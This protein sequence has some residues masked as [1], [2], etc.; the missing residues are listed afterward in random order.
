MPSFCV[1]L[2]CEQKY[3]HTDDVSFHRFPKE[4]ELS[5][6]WKNFTGRCDDWHP[7]RWSAIC[8]RHFKDSDFRK[9]ATRKILK[10]NA[11]P[12]I[13]SCRNVGSN[14][15]ATN[16]NLSQSISKENVKVINDSETYENKIFGTDTKESK[17]ISFEHH[18]QSRDSNTVTTS[19]TENALNNVSEILS[20]PLEMPLCIESQNLEQ[21]NISQQDIANNDT[22]QYDINLSVNSSFLNF[23]ESSTAPCRLCGQE[24]HITNSFLNDFEI[25]GMIQKCMPTLNI[26]QDD[27]FSKEVCSNCLEQ[28]ENFNAF[29][30]QVILHQKNLMENVQAVKQLGKHSTVISS[31]KIKQEPVNN[32]KM[33]IKQEI[34][35][36]QISQHNEGTIDDRDNHLNSVQFNIQDQ[37]EPFPIEPEPKEQKFLRESS[38]LTTREIVKNCDIIEIIN[39]EDG[40]IDIPDDEIDDPQNGIE[41]INTNENHPKVIDNKEIRIKKKITEDVE[42]F[43]KENIVRPRVVQNVIGEHN[44]TRNCDVEFDLILKAN[45]YKQEEPEDQMNNNE[46]NTTNNNSCGE[47]HD[48]LTSNYVLH[49]IE[50]TNSPKKTIPKKEKFSEKSNPALKCIENKTSCDKKTNPMQIYI[51]IPKISPTNYN[52]ESLSTMREMENINIAPESTDCLNTP[53]NNL[54]ISNITKLKNSNKSNIVVINESILKPGDTQHFELYKCLE[55]SIQFFSVDNFKEHQKFHHSASSFNEIKTSEP[56]CTH[57]CVLCETNFD[58]FYDLLK[59]RSKC[60]IQN[61][62]STKKPNKNL[63]NVYNCPMCSKTF[64]SKLALNNHRKYICKYPSGHKFIC[65][66]CGDNFKKW[67]LCRRHEK[68]CRIS[69]LTIINKKE[70]LTKTKRKEDNGKLKAPSNEKKKILNCK[71]QETCKS[72]YCCETCN[73][74]YDRYQNLIRHKKIHRPKEEWNYKCGSCEK[75]FD[76]MYD[77]KIHLKSAECPCV[78]SKPDTIFFVCQIC[79][80]KFKTL[81]ILKEHGVTH[82]DM[83]SYVCQICNKS[84]KALRNLRQHKITHTSAKTVQCDLCDK[85]FK[86]LN[87][88]LQHKRGFHLKIKPHVC[89]VCKHA[90]SLKGDMLRCKH[91]Y[92]NVE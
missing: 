68:I 56:I 7:S 1:V 73:R 90:Y 23:Y 62:F 5:N 53:E 88:L 48:Q 82:S 29:V 65:K 14:I 36:T 9:Y 37:D 58:S 45:E 86:R 47:S 49:K 63:K 10:K 89:G 55:C 22:Q 77:L 74:S 12:T 21:C 26:R 67:I 83:F 39:L 24:D 41:Q 85:T 31:V 11:I 92:L 8:S 81:Q 57:F 87:G 46:I 44:Y 59:H 38:S 18:L 28:L 13:T 30:D 50:A 91:K 60:R 19:E 54:L 32:M 71:E 52:N 33:N 43:S 66:Y 6:Q 40:Y 4:E 70:D 15:L 17:I 69:H 35:D 25:F 78:P 64:I 20:I 84:F 79:G 76:R 2:D 75:R 27:M 61:S 16:G 72:R 80:K 42:S 34:L 51:K 3:A